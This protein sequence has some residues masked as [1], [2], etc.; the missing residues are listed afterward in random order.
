MVQ[1]PAADDERVVG[2]QRRHMARQPGQFDDVALRL[3]GRGIDMDEHRAAAMDRSEG[4]QRQRHVAEDQAV[5]GGQRARIGLGRKVEGVDLAAR[6]DLAQMVVGTAIPQP[7]FEDDPCPPGDACRSPVEDEALRLH[8]A[9]ETVEAA[10]TVLI[11][12]H[13]R[14]VNRDGIPKPASAASLPK[15][16]SNGL[17]PSK[18][19]RDTLS[20]R[21]EAAAKSLL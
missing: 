14:E 8:A 11:G 5:G 21:K 9:D 7:E 20:R 2:S 10:H 6:Q 16:W 13:A 19:N 15:P 12:G 18:C 3:A 4:R 1:R 17:I